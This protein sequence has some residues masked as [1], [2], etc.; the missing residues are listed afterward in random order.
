MSTFD[1]AEKQVVFHEVLD[2]K[3]AG[4][5]HLYNCCVGFFPSRN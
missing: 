3:L 1:I 2:A 4:I 5:W